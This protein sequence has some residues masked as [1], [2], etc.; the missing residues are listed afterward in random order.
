VTRD[1]LVSEIAA[2]VGLPHDRMVGPSKT[3]Y[4]REYPD[5]FVMFN[6]TL[7]DWAGTRLWWG[8]VDLTL[9]EAKLAD[10]ARRLAMPVHVFF[11]HESRFVDPI[12]MSL[13]AAV[14]ETNGTARFLGRPP[15]KRDRAGR[16]VLARAPVARPA[17]GQGSAP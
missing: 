10:L 3:G 5:H 8:D 9:D 14:F 11:E 7:T 12:A 16:V 15:T 1:R 6:A 2:L 17:E 4:R 13:A